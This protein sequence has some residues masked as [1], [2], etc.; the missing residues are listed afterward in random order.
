MGSQGR[1]GT[2]KSRGYW[3][4]NKVS[5]FSDRFLHAVDARAF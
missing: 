3:G 4:R 2:S 5:K 1:V